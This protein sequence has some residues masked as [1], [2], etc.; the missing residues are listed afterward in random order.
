MSKPGGR[1][2]PA[3]NSQPFFYV[4]AAEEARSEAC[5]LDLVH[6]AILARVGVNV[7]GK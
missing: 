7:Q 2:T 5:V 3:L 1:N 6:V 4:P